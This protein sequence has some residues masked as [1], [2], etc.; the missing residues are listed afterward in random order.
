[1]RQCVLEFQLSLAQFGGLVNIID[2]ECGYFCNEVNEFVEIILTLLNNEKVYD[3]KSKLSM[4]KSILL[5]NYNEYIEN[6]KKNME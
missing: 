6:I 3:K 4:K 1:M 2:N 5:N